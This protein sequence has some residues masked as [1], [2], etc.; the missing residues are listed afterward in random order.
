[1]P[2]ARAGTSEEQVTNWTSEKAKW[3]IG[4]SKRFCYWAI[5]II[6]IKSRY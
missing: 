3:K 5:C 4:K 2:G 1:M 6:Y